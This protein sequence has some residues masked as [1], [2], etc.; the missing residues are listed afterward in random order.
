MLSDK[1][2]PFL[3]VAALS[4]ELEKLNNVS[5]SG[6][7]LLETGEGVQNAGRHLEAWLERHDARAV[8]SIGFAG[9]L[10]SSLQPGDIV[11]A[12]EVRDSASKPDHA[13]LSAAKDLRLGF[14]VVL[15]IALTSNEIVWKAEAKHAL[16]RSLNKDEVGF[17]DMES[18]AIARVCAQRGL[19]FLIARSITDLLDEDLPFNF[20]LYRN[21]DG[22]VE[23]KR[24]IKAALRKPLA[25][26]GLLALRKRSQL[27]A[28]HI[29]AFVSSLTDLRSKL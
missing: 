19:P 24:V 16:A 27:C 17:V 14:P 7:V 22:R 13:L 5:H 12:R 9:G 20:N 21:H 29:A 23:S 6:V 18:T 28:E 3:V 25:I 26:K 4:Y 8:L 11:V 2:A 10:S 15:G 1:E